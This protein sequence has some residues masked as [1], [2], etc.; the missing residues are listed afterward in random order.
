MTKLCIFVGTTVFGIAGSLLAGALG[1]DAFS[2]GGFLLSGVGSIV[3]VYLGWKL[4]QKL[5]E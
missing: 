3:G 1:M 4:A 5:A 2:L